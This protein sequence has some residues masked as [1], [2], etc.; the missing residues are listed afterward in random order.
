MLQVLLS[1]W[2][3]GSLGKLSYEQNNRTCSYT[4][5]VIA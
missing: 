4:K 3:V 5:A 2:E 1:I